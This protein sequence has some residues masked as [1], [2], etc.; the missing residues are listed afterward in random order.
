MNT[1]N[2]PQTNGTHTTVVEVNAHGVEVVPAFRQYIEDKISSLEQIW[3]RI[4][5]AHI[6][7][8]CERNICSSEITLVSGGLV[9]RGEMRAEDP[10]VAFDSA[11]EKIEKQLRRYK[12]KAQ[13]RERRHDNRNGLELE[14]AS[15]ADMNGTPHAEREEE[16]Y[17]THVR[18]KQFVVKPM[19]ADEAALQMDLLGHN[20]Y[21]FRDAESNDVSVVYKRH[22]GGYGLLEPVLG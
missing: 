5:D 11:V 1:Q 3:P 14:R 19:S 20:F 6:N 9:T 18:T 22:S 13:T 2:A 12:K 15:V 21:V 7:L 10:R 4:D 17:D 16:H 8:N